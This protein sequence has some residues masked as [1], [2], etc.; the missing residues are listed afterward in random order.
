MVQ[1][2]VWCVK[3]GKYRSCLKNYGRVLDK[4]LE[5]KAKLGSSF[6]ALATEGEVAEAFGF[7]W[8]V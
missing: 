3:G 5:V 1:G 6:V 4:C 2:S 8:L 7:Q